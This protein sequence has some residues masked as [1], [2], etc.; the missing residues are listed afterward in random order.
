MKKR[1]FW[2]ITALILVLI[3]YMVFNNLSISK[4]RNLVDDGLDTNIEEDETRNSVNDEE[5]TVNLLRINEEGSVDVVVTFNNVIEDDDENLVFQL[6]FN[7]HSV[8][9]DNIEFDKLSIL[10]TSEDIVID[11]EFIWEIAGGGGHH[12]YG[13]L[14]IPKEYKGAPIITKD[15]K[16]IELELKSFGGAGSRL[17][18]WEK[19]V[20]D[21]Y[22]K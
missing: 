14:K 17:F 18:K 2:V 10:K 15:T 6:N 16:F 3:V 21:A 9:L 8:N 19:D 22:F 20:I 12:M 5:E 4:E 13:Y 7:T 1:V 11:N